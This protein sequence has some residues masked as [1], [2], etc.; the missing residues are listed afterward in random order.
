MN[1]IQADTH[2]RSY[3][4]DMSPVLQPETLSA[5]LLSFPPFPFS[6]ALFLFHLFTIP[7]YLYIIRQIL[8]CNSSYLLYLCPYSIYLGKFSWF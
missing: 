8:S 1:T 7:D 2:I 3:G 4:N 6:F 5:F